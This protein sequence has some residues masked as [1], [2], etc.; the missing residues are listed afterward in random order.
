MRF[1]LPEL[2]PE[3]QGKNAPEADAGKEKK[4][5]AYESLRAKIG[6]TAENLSAPIQE[7]AQVLRI[8]FPNDEN[9]DGF[10]VDSQDA[11]EAVASMPPAVS[12]AMDII[13]RL[14]S[15]IMVPLVMPVINIVLI[16]GLSGLRALPDMYKL[17]TVLIVL[18]FNTVLPMVLIGLLKML[19]IV[20]DLGL[21]SRSER[22]VPYLIT[23]TGLICTILFLRHNEAA[24]WICASYIGAAIASAICCIVNFWWKISAHAAGA[25]GVLGTLAVMATMGEAA[26]G[27]QWWF[28]AACMLTGLMGSARVFLRRHTDMQVL[29][30]YICGFCSVYITAII[31]CR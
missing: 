18:G 17:W 20:R 30:G 19:G 11:D 10:E 28:F 26:V 6:K 4:I 14:L 21:N 12:G 13:C 16:L 15:W 2:P 31:M 27:L 5:S 9:D 22:L 25:A 24:D 8:S 1:S 23:I 29:A 3:T 7:K